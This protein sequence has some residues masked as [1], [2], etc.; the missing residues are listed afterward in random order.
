MCGSNRRTR[1]LM[2]QNYSRNNVIDNQFEFESNFQVDT[3]FNF[4]HNCNYSQNIKQAKFC[5][6]CGVELLVCPISKMKFSINQE[7]VQ[8]KNC[9]WV[10]HKTHMDKWM[11]KSNSC[12]I[13][14][15]PPSQM[16]AGVISA[17]SVIN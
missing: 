15:N 2:K 1:I 14:K 12:P 9:K 11:V 4:C 13:C 3:N 6:K 10:F 16:I 17:N 7:F 5:Q 8:C